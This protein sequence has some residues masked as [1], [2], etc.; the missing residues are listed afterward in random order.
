MKESSLQIGVDESPDPALRD[1]IA[2]LLKAFNE[3]CGLWLCTSTFQ[4]PTI[5]YLKRLD[6]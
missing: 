2:E 1:A 3:S 5:Y 4:A 6:A